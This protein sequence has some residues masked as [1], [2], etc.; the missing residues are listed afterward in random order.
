MNDQRQTAPKQQDTPEQRQRVARALLIFSPF[1]FV[2]C[3]ILARVQDASLRDALIIATAGFVM[4]LVS[5]AH[6]MLRGMRSSDDLF[7][8]TA[9]FNLFRR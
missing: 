7:W 9:I 3:W 1:L 4:C 2:F 6:Y 8:L 5:A